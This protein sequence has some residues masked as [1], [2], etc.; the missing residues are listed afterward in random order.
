MGRWYGRR[1]IRDGGEGPAL[2]SSKIP[3][4]AAATVVY[5]ALTIMVFADTV[6][7][8]AAVYGKPKDDYRGAAALIALSSSPDAAVISVGQHSSCR[9]RSHVLLARDMGRVRILDA[10]QI[11]DRFIEELRRTRGAVWAAV[12]QRPPG[13]ISEEG[14]EVH[15]FTGITIARR[16]ESAPGSRDPLAATDALRR[17]GSAFHSPQVV[18]R[19]TFKALATADATRDNILPPPTQA[20]VQATRALREHWTLMPGSSLEGVTMRLEPKGL[21]TNVVF[22]TARLQPGETYIVRFSYYN[23]EL[24]GAQRVYVSAHDAGGR[25]LDIF[26]TGAGYSCEP[27]N[28]WRSGAFGFGVPPNAA[29]IVVWLRAKGTGSAEFRDVEV[30]QI[31]LVIPHG[32]GDH[33]VPLEKAI[34]R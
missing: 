21:S 1:S 23:P 12:F 24:Q 3:A 13:G 30:R 4:P 9:P 31:V 18:S 15:R 8:L 17:W 14:L 20:L 7:R 5:V 25:W 19:S 22:E 26:P 27:A 29:S 16:A 32:K 28:G 6:P 33:A 11:D 34:A 10:A 2:A